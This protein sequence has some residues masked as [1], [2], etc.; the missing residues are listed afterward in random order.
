MA[1]A[2]SLLPLLLLHSSKFSISRLRKN[3]FQ[4]SVEGEVAA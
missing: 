3:G 2:T 1:S 4:S